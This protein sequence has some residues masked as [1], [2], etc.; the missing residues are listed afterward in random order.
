MKGFLKIF[1]VFL[2]YNFGNS[3][4]GNGPQDL[5]MLDISYNNGDI[6][7]TANA[8]IS[9]T[10]G[11]FGSL[12]IKTPN[13]ATNANI[14]GTS[15]TGLNFVS[16]FNSEDIGEP[17]GFTYHYFASAVVINPSTLFP[18]NTPVN[19]GTISV[20]PQSLLSQSELIMT[21]L[22]PPVNNGGTY[23]YYRT[24]VQVCNTHSFEDNLVD[25]G[26]NIPLPIILKTFS[27]TRLGERSARLDWVTSSEVNSAYF[28]VERSKDALVWENI[29]YVKAAGDSH[30][31]KSYA[32][33]DDQLPLGRNA[34]QVYYYRLML[35]DLDG[36]FNYSN[37]RGVNFRNSFDG[38]IKVYPNP[39]VS[40][41]NLDLSGWEMTDGHAQLSIFD[42]SGRQMMAKDIIGNGLELLEVSQ[43]PAGTYQILISQG[44]KRNHFRFVKVD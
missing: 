40:Y 9:Y 34:G 7:V 29:G 44:Q 41:V 5:G 33:I 37:I 26:T 20:T 17:P 30:S 19:I 14:T 31:E 25:E 36:Q 1:I 38:V 22:I 32:F 39:A 2:F 3:Q 15:T 27:A 23:S 35:V 18:I 28:G 24:A 6:I 13:T 8:N 42:N 12:I 21:D 16:S 10:S 11:L 4:C 43:W